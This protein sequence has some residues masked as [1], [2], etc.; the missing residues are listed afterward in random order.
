MHACMHA[1]MQAGSVR[2]GYM[3]ACIRAGRVSGKGIHVCM[4]SRASV[5]YGWKRPGQDQQALGHKV[6]VADG[7]GS[8]GA[9]AR[10]GSSGRAR[11]SRR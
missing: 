11:I 5:D 8:A 6:A 3:H 10:G 4:H 7:P 1:Y 9:R 2:K